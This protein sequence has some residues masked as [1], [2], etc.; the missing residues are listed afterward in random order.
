MK[1]GF[2]DWSLNNYH[3]NKFHGL[4]A[5]GGVEIVAAYEALPKG[6][7][8]CAGKG[9]KRADN[10][11]QVIDASEGIIVLAPDDTD[12]HLELS[13]DALASGKPVFVDKNLATSN[14]DAREMVK[15]AAENDTPL[16][17][18]SSLRFSAELE[19]ML[20][21]AGGKHLDG[22]FSRGL[23]KWRGYSVHSIAPAL[24]M[25]GAPVKRII[26]T[27]KGSVHLVTIE[28]SDGR[29]AF[30]DLRKCENQMEATPWQIG[31]LDG[32]KYD[33]ATITKFDEFYANLMKQTVKFFETRNSPVPTQEMLDTVAVE[34][35]ADKSMAAGGEWV[36]I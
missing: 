30:I 25:L 13:R 31:H 16:M 9:V 4:L 12:R 6:D 29:R 17:S 5:G 34:E 2:I 28:T 35:A 15:I 22:I 27:G 21:R 11:Q 26:D 20:Q 10:V 19:E 18:A 32:D 24:R 36:E 14:A 7:D 23:G 1:V 8:W 3:A 33:V